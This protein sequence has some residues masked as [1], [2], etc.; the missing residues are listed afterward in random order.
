MTN[1]EKSM[2]AGLMSSE[3]IAYIQERERIRIAEFIRGRANLYMGETHALLSQI[4]GAV[5]SNDVP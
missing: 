3:V 5:R 2:A 1:Q 4:A